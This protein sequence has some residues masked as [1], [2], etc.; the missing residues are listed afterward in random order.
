MVKVDFTGLQKQIN[1]GHFIDDAEQKITVNFNL[2]F[3]NLILL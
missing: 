3:I 1:V 2:N